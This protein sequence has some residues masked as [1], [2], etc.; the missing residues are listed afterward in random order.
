[1]FAIIIQHKNILGNF[2]Y[3]IF[4]YLQK[5]GS[6]RIRLAEMKVEVKMSLF[7]N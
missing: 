6:N 5:Y 1:M 3:S 4:D 2:G 7:L